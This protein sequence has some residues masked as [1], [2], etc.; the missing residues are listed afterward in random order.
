[1]DI[2]SSPLEDYLVMHRESSVRF[3]LRREEKG[4]GN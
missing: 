1:M 3:C 4:I 2:V